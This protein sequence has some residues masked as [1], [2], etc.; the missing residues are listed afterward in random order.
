MNSE[1]ED[2]TAE[3]DCDGPV[4]AEKPPLDAGDK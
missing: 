3:P 4:Y 2:V 1:D